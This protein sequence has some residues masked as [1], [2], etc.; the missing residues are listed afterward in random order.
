M[1]SGSPLVVVEEFLTVEL[2]RPALPVYFLGFG[3]TPLD[4]VPSPD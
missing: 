2:R 1:A 4:L 3:L